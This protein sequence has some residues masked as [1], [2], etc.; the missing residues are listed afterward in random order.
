M[1]YS[2][3]DKKVFV[4]SNATFLENDYMEKF[5]PRS[6]VV[7]EE[8]QSDQIRPRPV[9]VTGECN[10]ETTNPIQDVIAPRRSGRVSKQPI[11]YIGVGEANV[12]VTDT[13]DD[14]PLSY[15]HAMDDPDKDK[16]LTA[17][18]QEMESMYSKYV[19][20]LIDLPES[21]RPIWCKWIYKKK[22]GVDGKV[23]T[24]KSWLVSKGYTQKEGVDYEDI[25]SPIAML[26]SIRILF[27][28]A[29]ALDYEIWKMNIK[30]AF[31]NGY[32]DESIYMMQP[33]GFIVEGQEQ[34][35]CKLLRSIYR[36]K[37]ASRSWNLRFDETIK[38][39]GFE[40]NIDVPCVYKYIKE[41]KVVFLVLYVADILLIE[42]DIGLLSDVKKWLVEKFQM[43]DLGQASY[44]LGI[45][46][47]RDRKNRLLAPSQES[48][49]DKVLARFSMQNSKKGQLPTQHGIVLSKEQ[50]PTKPREEEE[51]RRVP[52]ASTV[53]SLTYAMLCTRPDIFYAIGIVSR[54][55]SN[56]GLAHWIVVKH[57]LKY[58][59]R[60]RNYMLIYS[61]AD[62]N[63][64][65]YTD[66]DFMS[67]KDRRKSTSG[68]VFTLGGGAV[69]WRSVKQS[70][71]ADSTMEAEYISACEAAKEAVWLKKFFTDLEVI[72][73]MDKPIVLYCDNSGAVAN[74]KEPRSHK[75]GKHIERK[76]HLIREIVNRGDVAVMKIASQDNLADPFT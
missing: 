61:G 72:P 10:K 56:P 58:L 55:Q 39:F 29:A 16:W 41:T 52:Y 40:Q 27:S 48:H 5:K 59:R 73:N 68:S 36:L 64:I 24:F 6:R 47:I 12:V 49:I 7:L 63:P 75:R 45:Q 57:I 13:S 33:K 43:K 53:G 69:V 21:V 38:T 62:L 15:K 28:I 1:F 3:Q 54:Y 66:S 17:M 18:E 23:D 26:K 11:R 74:S 20:E 25:F 70:S 65:G 51:M 67:N 44:V 37:Q 31:L 30:R 46:I 14:D 22:R 4:S 2:P 42:N 32:L 60:T 71:I 8:L 50:C 76:Y 19:G 9:T 35:V 34:K